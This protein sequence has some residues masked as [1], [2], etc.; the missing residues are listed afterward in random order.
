MKLKNLQI[1]AAIV[2]L[3]ATLLSLQIFGATITITVRGNGRVETTY[4][5]DG[6]FST[7]CTSDSDESCSFSRSF[8]TPN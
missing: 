5:E 4:H 3:V 7:K 2:L 1:F 6:T 8:S